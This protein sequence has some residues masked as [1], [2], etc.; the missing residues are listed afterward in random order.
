MLLL[1][2]QQTD[3]LLA[4]PNNALRKLNA[5]LD[6]ELGYSGGVAAITSQQLPIATDIDVSMVLLNIQPESSSSTANVETSAPLAQWPQ[7][8]LVKL[9]SFA[10]VA[11]PH[12]A[13]RFQAYSA[14]EIPIIPSQNV[15]SSNNFMMSKFFLSELSTNF[16]P[17]WDQ[18]DPTSSNTPVYLLALNSFFTLSMPDDSYAEIIPRWGAIAAVSPYDMPAKAHALPAQQSAQAL[19]TLTAQLRTLL[20]FPPIVYDEA[21]VR[22]DEFFVTEW[23]MA[24]WTRVRAYRYAVAASDTL[25]AMHD[26][27]DQS[28]HVPL[29]SAQGEKVRRAMAL[30][31]GAAGVEMPA[32]LHNIL[33]KDELNNSYDR[34]V[35][36]LAG[37]Y[38]IVTDVFSDPSMSP[39]LYFPPEHLYAVLAPMFAPMLVPLLAAL[40]KMAKG[41]YVRMKHKQKV[42]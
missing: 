1:P 31:H 28:P 18:A 32:P 11:R 23:E 19:A 5:R 33:E 30:M 14:Y 4:R 36:A 2:S 39:S 25:K 42:E 35:E 20:G 22:H 38:A 16:R 7:D 17:L 3:T 15:T 41:A 26:M 21:M 13:L 29:P 37:A 8:I 6:K 27:L 12:V 10:S 34:K 40:I 24:V 9:H